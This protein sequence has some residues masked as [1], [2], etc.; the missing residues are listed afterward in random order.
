MIKISNA[1][2]FFNDTCVLDGVSLTLQK[3]TIVGL[4]GPSGSGKSTLLRC[5]QGFE[6]L[7][8]GVIECHGETGF[9]FQDFQL[10]PHMTVLQNITYAPM[11]A[12]SKENYIPQAM[13]LLERL[14]M[15]HK[16]QAYPGTLSGGQK[17][18]GALARMLMMNPDIILCDEPTSGLDVATIGDVVSLLQSVKQ[19]GITMIIASHDL[20]FLSQLADRIILLKAGKI[21]AD[22]MVA[23]SENSVEFFKK[24]Y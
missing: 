14:N 8:D 10:F 23:D 13:A 3:S 16:A 20:D 12:S 15:H 17:Q 5:I 21:V 24:Y 2:K 1:K 6:K 4:A 9:M 11:L 7:D 18:R 19:N 22:S